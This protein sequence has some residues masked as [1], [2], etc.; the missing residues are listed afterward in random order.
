MKAF[1]DLMIRPLNS[2]ARTCALLDSGRTK[3]YELIGDRK[4]EALKL[5][6]ATRITGPSIR[7]LIQELPAAQI[8]QTLSRRRQ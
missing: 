7:R 6:G 5:D 4:L 1:L 8:G 3:V 2:V